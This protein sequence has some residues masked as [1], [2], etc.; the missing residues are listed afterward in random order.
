MP[1][2]FQHWPRLVDGA[3][4]TIQ[5]TAIA[6]PL[7]ICLGL[8]IALGR[9]SRLR[10]IR[11]VA[12]GFVEVVR[13][14]PFLVQLFWLFFALPLAGITLQPLVAG[15]LALTLHFAAYA[16]EIFR[17]GIQSIPTGEL[18]AAKVLGLG[19]FTTLRRVILPRALVLLIPPIGNNIIEVFKATSLLALITVDE[20]VFYAQRL[21]AQ[22]RQAPDVWI[23][24]A[25]FYFIV[26]FPATVGINWYERHAARRYGLRRSDHVG[27]HDLTALVRVARRVLGFSATTTRKTPPGTSGGEE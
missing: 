1:D 4:V 11:W 8:L 21:T 3:L 20:I 26:S 9:M 27:H 2:V 22:T 15:I 14:T 5:V 16:S 25:F 7:F 23:L 17:A 10:A 6:T 13:G 24:V 12:G 19:S 18:D